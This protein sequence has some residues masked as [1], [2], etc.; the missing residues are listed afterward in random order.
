MQWL[1]PTVLATQEA[2]IRRI[3]VQDQPE[4]KVSDTSISTKKSLMW[5]HTPVIPGT[6]EVHIGLQSRPDINVRP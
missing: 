6:Q 1:T 5:W 3:I 4:Q 2:E